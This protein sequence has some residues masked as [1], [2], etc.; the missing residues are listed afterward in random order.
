MRKLFFTLSILILSLSLTS[1]IDLV[2][3]VSVNE[4]LSG[5]YEMRLE[6]S[7]FGGL[8]GQMGGNIDIPQISELDQRLAY[9]R[10]QPG[11][12]NVSKNI[13]AKD[14]KFNVRF[15]FED[16]EALNNALY[17]MAQAE[18]NMFV[19]KI[20][21]VKKNKVIRPNLS[22]Y[23]QRLLEEQNLS[24]Q[25]PSEDILNYINYKFIVNTPKKV[26]RVSGDR[27]QIQSNKTTVISSYSF[28]ELLID[29]KNVYLKIRM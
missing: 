23:L 17:A 6:A 12:S 18:P 7:G 22:P 16:E 26:K 10:N 5:T 4:D 20:L 29:Q 28:R 11:I 8:M 3:E 19:K 2:E 1:C 15:D 14:L 9:L 13:M 27:A 21:K 24:D 25:L